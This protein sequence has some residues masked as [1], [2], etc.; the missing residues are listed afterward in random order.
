LIAVC[1]TCHCDVH[2]KV[3]FTRSFTAKELKGHRDAV[4]SLVAQGKLPF[5]EV[6]GAVP[7]AMAAV[8]ELAPVQMRQV[9]LSATQVEMLVTAGTAK[10][11]EQGLV[12]ITMYQITMGA[13][14]IVFPSQREGARYRE[15]FKVLV[16]LGVLDGVRVSGST[17]FCL[18]SEGL[19]MVDQLLALGVQDNSV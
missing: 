13:R 11:H 14:K 15:A 18:N 6:P 19:R 3:P 1:L 12:E 4:Y 8:E 7:D 16:G 2:T 9:S 17:M 10:E 5:P